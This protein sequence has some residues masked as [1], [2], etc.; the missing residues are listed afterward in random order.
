MLIHIFKVYSKNPLHLAAIGGFYECMNLLL[1]NGA[2]NGINAY[3][4]LDT[5]RYTALHFCALENNSDCAKLLLE[6]GAAVDHLS[7]D[8]KTPLHIACM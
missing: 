3:C 7:N 6:F 8:N 5:E 2:K 4:Q 1:Q